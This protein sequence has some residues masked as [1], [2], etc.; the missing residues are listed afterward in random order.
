ML[1][2]FKQ[3]F[4]RIIIFFISIVV[5]VSCRIKGAHST[6]NVT[7]GV[8][9]GDEFPEVVQIFS[10]NVTST[11]AHRVYSDLLFHNEVSLY[12]KLVRRPQMTFTKSQRTKLAFIKIAMSRHQRGKKIPTVV[13]SHALAL[14]KEGLGGGVIAKQTGLSHK[15]LHYWRQK[16]DLLTDQHQEKNPPPLIYPIELPLNQGTHGSPPLTLTIGG[17]DITIIA[18]AAC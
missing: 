9:A 15:T 18:K 8:A 1:Y 6:L 2:R 4:P 11:P 13:K 17:F 16:H 3:N 10:Y 5:G 14:L 12:K 7:N